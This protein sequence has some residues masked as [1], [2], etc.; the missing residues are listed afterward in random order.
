MQGEGVMGLSIIIPVYNEAKRLEST[1]RAVE[2][3][4]GRMGLDSEIIIAEDGSTDQ[5]LA[6]AKRLQSE[7]IRLV[8]S[9]LRIGKGKAIRNASMEARGGIIAFMDA[10][11]ASDP[12]YL[13]SLIHGL[14]GGAAIAIG[15]R[16]V[17]GSVVKRK[18]MRDF[19]SRAFNLIIA[20][21]WGSKVRDHQCGF[22]A[23]RRDAVVP[24]LGEIQSNSWF[25]DTEFLVRAQEKGLRVVEVPIKWNEAPTSNFRFSDIFGMMR[26]IIEFKL[27]R[28]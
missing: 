25:W 24:W 2:K 6:I 17:P 4:L 8:H 22:K 14:D 23:F 26:S 28:K 11:L 18:L 27:F 1:V 10:D 21:L 16:Y 3:E 12:A 7:R 5:T 19:Y 15:S 13:P 20:V 9:S